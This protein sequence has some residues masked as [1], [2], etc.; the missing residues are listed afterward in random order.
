MRAVELTYA[1][2]EALRIIDAWEGA[3]APAALV[4]AR[5]GEGHGGTEAPRGLLYHRYR[6]DGEGN[7]LDAQIVPPT[8]QN[9]AG[10]EA[11]LR[12]FV[13]DRLHLDHD[14]LTRQCEQAIRNY[15]PC[16]SCATHFLDVHVDLT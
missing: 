2:D 8:A 7:I 9:Q 11:D 12:A 10:I 3:P 16:I 6:L 1:F 15:D 14:E 13:Q 5:A 4:P